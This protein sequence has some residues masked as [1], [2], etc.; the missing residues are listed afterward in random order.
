M[1]A[2]LPILPI[3]TDVMK[4]VAVLQVAAEEAIDS[5]DFTAAAPPLENLRALRKASPLIP[6]LY[7][8]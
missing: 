6:I 4:K 3:L 5:G 1:H 8:R 2:G 7:L